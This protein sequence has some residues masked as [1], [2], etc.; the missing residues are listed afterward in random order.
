M[1]IFASAR[2]DPYWLEKL[3]QRFEVDHHDWFASGGFLPSE[4][5][6]DRL[7]GCR[8]LITESDTIGKDVLENAPDLRV[9][10]DCRGTPTNID[11]ETAT[12]QG[13]LVINAPGRNAEA[14]ADLTVALMIM[15]T[16]NLKPGAEALESGSWYEKGKRWCYITFQGGELPGKTVGLVGLGAIG[17]LVIQ[18]LRGFDMDFIGFDPYLPE[19]KAAELGVELVSLNE[20]MER[21]DFV[22]LHAPLNNETRGLLG[23]HEFGLMKPSAYFINTARAAITDEAALID[24]LMNQRIAGAAIDVFH[25][26]PVPGDYPLLHLDH[27]VAIPHLGGATREVIA[28][29]SRIG[30]EGL[31]KLLEGDPVN[32]VNPQVLEHAL[33]SIEG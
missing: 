21:S 33:S 18:R 8:V 28:H 13:I 3:R 16:R 25:E 22:S 6:I 7:Q 4:E 11:M 9:I 32:L 5:M 10:V 1:K 20:L 2:L 31:F 15:A 23:A 27:V 24:I 14:V 17:Q 19:A 29:Q 26:E 12:A 30:I